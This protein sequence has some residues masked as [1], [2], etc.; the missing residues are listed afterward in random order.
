MQKLKAFLKH[1][2]FNLIVFFINTFF[3]FLKDSQK[4]F[5]V[6]IHHLR[7]FYVIYTMQDI[8]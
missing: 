3:L 5:S 8:F 7:M 2:F 1:S 6:C 4:T